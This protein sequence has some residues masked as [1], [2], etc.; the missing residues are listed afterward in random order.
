MRP[1]D[2]NESGREVSGLVYEEK[3]LSHIRYDAFRHTFTPRPWGPERAGAVWKG[4]VYGAQLPRVLSRC[5][6]CCTRL[7]SSSTSVTLPPAPTCFTAAR[8]RRLA[9]S[10][11][12]DTGRCGGIVITR[13][14]LVG[15]CSPQLPLP[16]ATAAVPAPAAVDRR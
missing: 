2:R 16:V 14:S 3:Q 5:P 6:Q 10:V 12:G 8:H 13:G 9:A 1:H 7:T 4:R 15:D 11:V